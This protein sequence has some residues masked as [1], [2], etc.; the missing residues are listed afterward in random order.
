MDIE[1]IRYKLTHGVPP[2]TH[3][4]CCELF[5]AAGGWPIVQRKRC[6]LCDARGKVMR[7]EVCPHCKGSGYQPQPVP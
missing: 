6:P 7:N 2:L 3:E 1:T 5:A 4:E